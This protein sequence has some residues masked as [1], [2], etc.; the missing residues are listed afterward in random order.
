MK[1][2]QIVLFLACGLLVACGEPLMDAS[3][4]ESRIT[5]YKK[6]YN[7]LPETEKKLFRLAYRTIEFTYRNHQAFRKKDETKEIVN[8]RIKTLIDGKNSRQIVEEYKKIRRIRALWDID[9]AKKRIVDIENRYK[10]LDKVVIKQY[11][12]YM[13]KDGKL[14]RMF[15][16]AVIQNGS[17]YRLSD[18]LFTIRIGSSSSDTLSPRTKRLY[19]QFP[20]ELEPGFEVTK[21]IDLGYPTSQKYLPQNPVLAEYTTSRITGRELDLNRNISP[22]LEDLKKRLELKKSKYSSE[23]NR[24]EIKNITI[25]LN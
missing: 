1:I 7:S 2:F 14:D 8:K 4:K 16:R 6:I 23:F 20:E 12:L 13:G 21:K 9:Q 10:Q 24:K 5:S 19:V 22:T 17:K 15:L 18:A 25:Y 3:T 11:E